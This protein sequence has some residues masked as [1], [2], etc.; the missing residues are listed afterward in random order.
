ML[1]FDSGKLYRELYPKTISI[2]VSGNVLKIFHI[3]NGDGV[4]L[5]QFRKEGNSIRRVGGG[6]GKE[7]PG[8]PWRQWIYERVLEPFLARSV[9]GEANKEEDLQ[10]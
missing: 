1:L 5:E 6:R 8:A 10:L 3:D 7:Y 9:R 2:E 4:S